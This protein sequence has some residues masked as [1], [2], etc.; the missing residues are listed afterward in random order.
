MTV[1]LIWSARCVQIQTKECRNKIKDAES[2]TIYRKLI[3][4]YLLT[5]MYKNIYMQIQFSLKKKNNLTKTPNT[6]LWIKSFRFLLLNS[7]V[8]SMADFENQLFFYRYRLLVSQQDDLNIQGT[9]LKVIK[10]HING[11][12]IIFWAVY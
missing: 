7:N 4:N 9:K 11:V 3:Q 10:F 8:R 1:L 6:S 2:P 5:F 12:C